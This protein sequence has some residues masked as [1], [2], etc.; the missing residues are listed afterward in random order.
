MDTKRQPP[1]ESR[2][3][4]LFELYQNKYK[5]RH[6]DVI[7]CSDNDAFQFL[8]NNRDRL[9]SDSPVVFC[10][11]NFFE[12]KMLAGQKGFTGVVEAFDLPSVLSL[13]LKLHPTTEQIVIVNDQTTT[14]K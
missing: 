7:I 10:G 1:T 2:L 12:D 13:M 14:G 3:A 8:L 4:E 11:V 9:F 5:N 6:F